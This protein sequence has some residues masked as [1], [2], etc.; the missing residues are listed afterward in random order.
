[1]QALSCP[2]YQTSRRPFASAFGLLP[3]VCGHKAAQDAPSALRKGMQSPSL[4]SYLP[5]ANFTAMQVS[6]QDQD[7]VADDS[8]DTP[9]SP[10]QSQ[11]T[12]SSPPPSFRSRASSIASRRGL[13]SD[14]PAANDAERTLRETFD[15]GSDSDDDAANNLDDRSRLIRSNTAG[16]S[17]VAAQIGGQST[18][19]QTS[20]IDPSQTPY[21]VTVPARTASTSHPFSSFSHSNDGVFANLNAK[22]E[23][24]EKLEEQPP[25]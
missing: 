14:D 17:R 15:D 20:Q 5:I 23:R 16:T 7:E 3:S 4:L 8:P 6:P 10:N 11:V 21:S 1:M 18:T 2:H 13:L 24:G 25:V 19:P 9:S 22:P 12:P